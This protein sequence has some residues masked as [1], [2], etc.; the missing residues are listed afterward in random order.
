[1]TAS[2]L[3]RDRAVTPVIAGLS[4]SGFRSPLKRRWKLIHRLFSNPNKVNPPAQASISYRLYFDIK[5]SNSLFARSKV[6]LL[7]NAEIDDFTIDREFTDIFSNDIFHRA[8]ILT[9]PGCPETG[10]AE[11][12][13]GVIEKYC[14]SLQLQW[15]IWV[16]FWILDL[17]F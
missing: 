4:F 14:G 5:R 3:D 1:V 9:D 13:E 12:L 11:G 15:R 2:L 7:L 8:R 6:V 17:L 10:M 16:K